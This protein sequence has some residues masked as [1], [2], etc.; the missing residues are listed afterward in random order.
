MD[1]FNYV[2]YERANF[3]CEIPCIVG[4]AKKIQIEQNLDMFP[5]LEFCYFCC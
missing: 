3:K 5:D 1:V 2:H 4:S